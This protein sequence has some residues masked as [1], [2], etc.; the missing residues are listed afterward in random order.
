MPNVKCDET[1]CENLKSGF[2]QAD[3]IELKMGVT[4]WSKKNPGE[5]DLVFECMQ[6]KEKE[7]TKNKKLW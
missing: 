4:S 6:F 2:C 5:F 7:G 3:N 1:D